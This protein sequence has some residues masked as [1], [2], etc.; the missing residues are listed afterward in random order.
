MAVSINPSPQ[1]ALPATPVVASSTAVGQQLSGAHSHA[2]MNVLHTAISMN[3]DMSALVSTSRSRRG[4][5]AR[6]STSATAWVDRVLDSKAGSKLAELKTTLLA[7]HASAGAV[8]SLLQ[9]LFSDPSDMV[10]VLRALIDDED[11]ES[12]QE[13]L[14]QTLHELMAEQGAQGNLRSVKAGL[15]AAIAARLAAHN[16][17]LLA[18][19]LRDCYRDFLGGGLDPI[20]QYEV[21]IEV[22]GFT[23]RHSV[24]EFIAGALSADIYSLDPSCSAIEFGQMLASVG[25]LRLLKAADAVIAKECWQ[26]ALMARLGVELPTLTREMLTVIRQG[27]GWAQLFDGCL[28]PVRVACS[29]GEISSL[30]QRFQRAL[31]SFPINLWP[32]P[33]HLIQA[34]E[35]LGAL[36]VQALQRECLA[37]PSVRRMQVSV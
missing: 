21:W 17:A 28:A 3:D 12:L 20:S 27:G 2:R 30:A 13:T 9:A 16:S 36:V 35:E 15:N 37:I 4:E 14:E 23:H 10:A 22:F 26:P 25:Q 33:G 19:D 31:R 6:S 29:P 11:L 18:A 24:V 34:Q 8:R 5:E 7:G 1:I 32:E